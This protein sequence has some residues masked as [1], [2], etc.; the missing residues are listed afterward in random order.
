MKIEVEGRVASQAATN[1]ISRHLA[2]DDD[3]GDDDEEQED[4][5]WTLSIILVIIFI[6]ASPSLFTTLMI[7]KQKYE[8]NNHC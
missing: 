3:H 1:S 5:Q 8:Q 6:T 2:S 7:N 4:V